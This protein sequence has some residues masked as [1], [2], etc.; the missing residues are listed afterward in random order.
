MEHGVDRRIHAVE[1]T[2]LPR[3]Q[4]AAQAQPAIAAVT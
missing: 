3:E 1:Q 2:D 4:G